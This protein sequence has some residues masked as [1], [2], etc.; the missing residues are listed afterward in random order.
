MLCEIPEIYV[1]ERWRLIFVFKLVCCGDICES[2][3]L[4]EI[5]GVYDVCDDSVIYVMY[6]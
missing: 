6:M 5:C 2:Y 3:N 4:C 1:C